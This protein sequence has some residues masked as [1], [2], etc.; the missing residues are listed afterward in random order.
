MT[1]QSEALKVVNLALRIN[2]LGGKTVSV[3]MGGPGRGFWWFVYPK[4]SVTPEWHDYFFL[5]THEACSKIQ[6]ALSYLE[7][8]LW[9]EEC[10]IA[11]QKKSGGNFAGA[12]T[13]V[14]DTE[15]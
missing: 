3:D 14:G 11:A 13:L 15:C 5:D 6:V 12:N 7:M 4:D 1:V 9:N 2:A 8:V 10:K